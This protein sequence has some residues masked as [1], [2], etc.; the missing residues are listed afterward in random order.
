MAFEGSPIIYPLFVTY[1]VIPP[2][3]SPNITFTQNITSGP[4]EGTTISQ[5]IPLFGSDSFIVNMQITDSCGAIFE[6]NHS[7]NPNPKV[8]LLKEE[9]SCGEFLNL[10]VK[11]YFPT[12]TINFTS[13]PVE[14]NPTD[15]N[16][17]YP[18]PFTNETIAFGDASN[19]VPFGTY[20]VNVTDACG[21]TGIGTI[22]VEEI[23]SELIINSSNNGC[24][25]S[26]G[27]I[28]VS[29]SNRELVSETII[30]APLSY[31]L[32]L[33]HNVDS[34]INNGI[35]SIQEN[36]PAGNYTLIVIDDCGLEY[37]IEAIVPDFVFQELNVVT[38]PN[39]ETATG[40]LDLSSNHGSL[41][42]VVIT[43]APATLNQNI[44]FNVSSNI[45]ASGNFFIN[46]LPIGNYVFQSTDECDFQYT[47]DV[48]INSY[49][50]N[51]SIYSLS[52]NCGSFDVSIND[53]DESTTNQSYWLQM[54]NT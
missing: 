2:D 40:S 45:N 38:L 43:S 51:P 16:P 26:S 13:F 48:T 36:L 49:S 1:N 44:P 24:S 5:I 50:S 15:Y 20:T 33:P 46:D 12:Y 3:S 54:F 14:F 39:C 52:L 21:R 41:T 10:N 47:T 6:V 30:A 4:P 28:S 25:A 27:F 22:T 18:G 9:A 8:N 32:P 7:I 23:L 11:N 53:L 19:L 17:N 34:F 29:V 35:L 37:T 31:S 42:S